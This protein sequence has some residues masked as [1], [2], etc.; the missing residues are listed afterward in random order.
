MCTEAAAV[1]VEAEEEEYREEAVL[2]E[3][4]LLEVAA[5]ARRGKRFNKSL[6]EDDGPTKGFQEDPTKVETR[7]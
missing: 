1:E 6:G 7:C 5:T 4:W 3:M 2:V